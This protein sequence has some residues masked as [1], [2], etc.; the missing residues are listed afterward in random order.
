MVDGKLQCN[1]NFRLDCYDKDNNRVDVHDEYT[2]NAHGL[3]D[4]QDNVIHY[5]EKF[6]ASCAFLEIED[7]RHPSYCPRFKGMIFGVFVEYEFNV[8]NIV[9]V[10]LSLNGFCSSLIESGQLVFTAIYADNYAV[11]V[12]NEKFSATSVFVK[13]ME[14]AR[15]VETPDD[16]TNSESDDTTDNESNGAAN[17]D[18]EDIKKAIEGLNAE[19]DNIINAIKNN[20]DNPTIN[21][22]N[23][24]YNF[25]GTSLELGKLFAHV[26]K[27]NENVLNHMSSAVEDM[28]PKFKINDEVE[29]CNHIGTHIIIS[30]VLVR[31]LE[32]EKSYVYL[33]KDINNK[34][35]IVSEDMLS[36]KI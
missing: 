9:R 35:I 5:K 15:S 19:A 2:F 26:D 13:R 27:I 33:V 8:E 34:E 32:N 30:S 28:I 22:A 1:Q 25:D 29:V 17:T 10:E 36:L 23:L 12:R 20:V 16:T 18:I 14:I 3:Q 21:I 24:N 6:D 31:S 11:V 4:V 7:V